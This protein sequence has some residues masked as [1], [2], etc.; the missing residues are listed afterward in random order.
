M[1]LA[2]G[3]IAIL[4]YGFSLPPSPFSLSSL[5][6]LSLY[7]C[8]SPSPFPLKNTFCLFEGSKKAD[9][10]PRQSYKDHDVNK[11]AFFLGMALPET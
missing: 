6:L 1:M 8:F 5:P 2:P 4:R 7:P 3:S 9:G 11:P 10:N